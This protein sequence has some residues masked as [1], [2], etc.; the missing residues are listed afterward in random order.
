MLLQRIAVE[1]RP[2]PVRIWKIL[3]T[4][5]AV[6]VPPPRKVYVD[7]RLFDIGIEYSISDR[8]YECMK[9]MVKSSI[10]GLAGIQNVKSIQNMGITQN[11]G[12]IQGMDITT[13]HEE[14]S[15]HG[16]SQYFNRPQ[17]MALK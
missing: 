3:W 1:A 7:Y 15:E 12:S 14:G 11:T 8:R 13:T 5:S 6:R 4:V 10:H 2:A 17:K 9:K 16:C